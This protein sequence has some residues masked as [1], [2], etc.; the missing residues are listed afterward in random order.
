MV[1]GGL[2]STSSSGHL[3]RYIHGSKASV[4]PR[5]QGVCIAVPFHHSQSDRVY[6]KPFAAPELLPIVLGL[7]HI[8]STFLH[9]GCMCYVSASYSGSPT[10]FFASWLY[11]P[12][13]TRCTG[14][15]SGCIDCR[16]STV[17]MVL[18]IT[19]AIGLHVT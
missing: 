17:E 8:S 9:D 11:Q 6:L 18:R 5:I 1:S 3:D 7:V 16:Q 13:Y 4:R 12:C 19:I 10:T 15:H 14:R 2:C